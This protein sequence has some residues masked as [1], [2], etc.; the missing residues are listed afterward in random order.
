MKTNNVFGVAYHRLYRVINHC[1]RSISVWDLD[2]GEY[3][4]GAK[5][6]FKSRESL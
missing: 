1:T 4:A 5:I 6:A 3:V 2:V